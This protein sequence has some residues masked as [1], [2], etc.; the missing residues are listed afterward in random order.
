M[1]G[2]GLNPGKPTLLFEDPTTWRGYDV[3]PDGRILVARVAQQKGVG[4][5][6]NVVLNW[7]EELKKLMKR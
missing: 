1:A 2:G 5:K 3:A 4:N 6:I 7:T